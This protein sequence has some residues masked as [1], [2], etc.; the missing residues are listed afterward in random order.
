MHAATRGADARGESLLECSLA[1]FV[2]ELDLPLARGM[3]GADGEESVA[4]G[5]QVGVRQQLLGVEHFGMRDGG[6]HVVLDQ[7]LVERVVVTR[8][9]REHPLVEIDA[10]V[11]EPAHEGGYLFACCSAADSALTSATISVP[12]PSFVNTSAR[13]PSPD[14]YDITC[15]RRTPPRMASSIALA[16]GSMP[17]TIFFSSR[18]FLRP[19]RSVYE[20]I[21]LGSLTSARMPGAPVHSMSFSASSAAPMAAATVSPLMLSSVPLSSAETGLTMGMRPLSSSLFNTLVSTL[22]M[23]P[24]KP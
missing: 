19:A 13:M 21:E 4:D 22:S 17:S 15:T 18:S 11:P 8:G 5:L 20:M 12:A 24:M 2:S 6:A 14:L 9:V 16:L 23:S 10:F 1:V 3:L 7:A